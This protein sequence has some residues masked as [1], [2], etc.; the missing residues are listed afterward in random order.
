MPER[1]ACVNLNRQ[2]CGED[3]RQTSRQGIGW[4]TVLAE[5]ALDADEF[6]SPGG[7]RSHSARDPVYNNA[8]TGNPSNWQGPVWGLSTFLTAYGLTRYGRVREAVDLADR[9]VRVFAADRRDKGF[10]TARR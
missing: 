10:L 2:K 3:R 4:T 9:Q 5:K 6:L 7:L 1:G 8:R